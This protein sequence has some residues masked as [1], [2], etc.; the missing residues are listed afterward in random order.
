MILNVIN[1]VAE[2]K[3][4]TARKNIH[5][6]NITRSTFIL[7]ASNAQ[8]ATAILLMILR[9]PLVIFIYVP[10]LFYTVHRAKYNESSFTGRSS[11]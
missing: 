5:D 9:D 10:Q 3:H 11:D 6:L 1:S 7:G 2:I 8:N 4:A